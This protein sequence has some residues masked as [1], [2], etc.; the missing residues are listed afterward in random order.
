MQLKSFPIAFAWVIN[1][2]QG[3]YE[4]FLDAMAVAYGEDI[5]TVF[6]TDKC[7]A[8]MNAL[9][10]KFPTNKR[11]L[12]IWHM[13]NNVSD[14]CAEKFKNVAVKDECVNSVY[15]VIYNITK[16]ELDYGLIT[17]QAAAGNI[18]NYVVAVYEY[19]ENEWISYE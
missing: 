13:L 4:W 1:E 5:S 10:K 12:C 18:N 9:N 17:F 3:M 8:L 16:L 6:V 2:T 11:L 7:Q 14:Y 19:F 15:K